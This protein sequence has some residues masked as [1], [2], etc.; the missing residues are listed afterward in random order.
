MG[1]D[2]LLAELA[3][4]LIVGES[5]ALSAAGMPGVG[6]TA[7]AVALA[8]HRRVLEHFDGGVLWAGLGP[9]PDVVGIQAAWAEAL[10]RDISLIADPERRRQII[11]NAI[12]Q[13][14]VLLVID[15]AWALKPVQLLCCSGQVVCLLT[16]RNDDLARRFAPGQ[17]LRVPELAE[18]PSVELL[19]NLAPEA[20]EADPDGVRELARSTGGLPLALM[21]LGGY[22]SQ[23][24]HRVFPQLMQQALVALSHPDVWLDER[25]PRAGVV[26]EF[27]LA[28]VIQLSL[29]QLARTRPEAVDAFYALGAFAPK[30][31][32]F[33]YQA[34]QVV[35]QCEAETLALL[36]GRN[37]LEKGDDGLMLHQALAAFALQHC[38]D[39][40]RQRHRD[41]Y[42]AQVEENGKDWQRIERLY[43]QILYAWDWQIQVMPDSR[44][45]VRF[46][47]ALQT[48][49]YRRGLRQDQLQWLEA[50]LAV[51]EKQNES[52]EIARF[53]NNIGGVYSALGEKEKALSYYEQ[54]LPLYRQVG[55]RGGEATTLNN[56]GMVYDALGEKEKALSYCEQ[57]VNLTHQIGDA[58]SEFVILGNIGTIYIKEE[59]WTKAEDHLQ[60]AVSIGEAIGH[61]DT[62]LYH[63]VLVLVKAKSGR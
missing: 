12:G 61:P 57:A 11:C 47:D 58:W 5:P 40:A 31:A 46:A 22:L 3:D 19:R 63:R 14:R 8:H 16:T 13:R 2:K 59:Q 20:W 36:I 54:A 33:Q 41:Y 51:V 1:R 39:E 23:A 37:L 4:R 17:H 42:L 35:T 25:A 62:E 52:G 45:V 38:S 10:E 29:D 56:I 53:L 27:T 21:V 18:G 28:A 49:Q 55:D 48:Y 50:G 60:R 24:E 30:P 15:D 32:R 43:P 6:K 44:Y 26:E 9:E 7:L 34:A